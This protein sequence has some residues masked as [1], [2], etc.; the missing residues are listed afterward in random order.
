MIN[1]GLFMKLQ[2]N[3]DE[4]IK[5]ALG[6]ANKGETSKALGILNAL[7]NGRAP[8][9]RDV[10]VKAALVYQGKVCAHCGAEYHFTGW[11]EPGHYTCSCMPRLTNDRYGFR[12][13]AEDEYGNHIC[14][15]NE[16]R[17]DGQD[18]D[19][20]LAALRKMIVRRRQFFE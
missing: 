10:V 18:V 15:T 17:F 12:L 4:L 9:P 14:G 6:L 13:E 2:D 1:K 16:V 20:D 7:V 19:K 5:S 8:M 11:G 3:Q